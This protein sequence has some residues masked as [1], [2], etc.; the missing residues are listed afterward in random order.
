MQGQPATGEAGRRAPPPAPPQALD[1]QMTGAEEEEAWAMEAE[2]EMSWQEQAELE[3]QVEH[4]ETGGAA[5]GHGV[6]LV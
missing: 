5:G 1:V 6:G 2:L 4:E 3:G